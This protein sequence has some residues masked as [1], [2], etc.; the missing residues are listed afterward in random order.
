MYERRIGRIKGQDRSG[1]SAP[2]PSE[3]DVLLAH[4]WL[5]NTR[6][7]V[8]EIVAQR[9]ESPQALILMASILSDLA[10]IEAR[11]VDGDPNVTLLY[12]TVARQDNS[13]QQ[14]ESSL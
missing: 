12:A 13:R 4:A 2:Q 8:I 7:E 9:A 6:S 3:D 10:A 14:S 5:E 11:L 1:E